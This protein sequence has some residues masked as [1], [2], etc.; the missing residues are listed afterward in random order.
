MAKSD[1]VKLML[2]AHGIEKDWVRSFEC[3]EDGRSLTV[4]W[5]AANM[6]KTSDI[7]FHLRADAIP[8]ACEYLSTLPNVRQPQEEPAPMV[9][10]A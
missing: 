5:Q 4:T 8:G 6:E 3:G 2:T 10:F 9:R 1:A 7:G